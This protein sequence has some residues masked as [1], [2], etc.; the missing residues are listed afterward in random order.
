MSWHDTIDPTIYWSSFVVVQ[1]EEEEEFERSVGN[2]EQNGQIF[3]SKITTLNMHTCQGE[4]DRIGMELERAPTP[5][6][7]TKM[8][9]LRQRV[10]REEML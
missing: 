1:Q 6:N 8:R 5:S 3:I 9:E 10:K 4:M 7:Q 2:G